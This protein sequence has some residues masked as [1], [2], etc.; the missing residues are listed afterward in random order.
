MYFF[1]RIYNVLSLSILIDENERKITRD[2]IIYF[3]IKFFDL[4]I[5]KIINVN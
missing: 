1:Y 3:F 5:L 4:L 2:Y